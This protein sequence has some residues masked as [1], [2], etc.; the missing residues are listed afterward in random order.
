MLQVVG[1]P[2]PRRRLGDDDTPSIFPVP[3]EHLKEVFPEKI[4]WRVMQFKDSVGA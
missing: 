2:V 1:Q 3:A 4:D